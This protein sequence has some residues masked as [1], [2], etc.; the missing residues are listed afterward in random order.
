MLKLRA[1]RNS[2]MST[3]GLR[4]SPPDMDAL[5][6][7]CITLLADVPAFDRKTM[8]ERLE[9]LRRADDVWHLRGALFDTISRVHGESVA[10]A[11]IDR[12]DAQLV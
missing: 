3:I 7:L 10:R 11:R 4:A 1:F 6:E 5:R 9:R 8:L 2:F 12:L